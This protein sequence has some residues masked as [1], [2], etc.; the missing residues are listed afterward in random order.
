MIYERMVIVMMYVNIFELDKDN[1]FRFPVES[2]KLIETGKARRLLN[3]PYF[4]QNIRPND[5]VTLVSFQDGDTIVL[6]GNVVIN[7]EVEDEDVEDEDVEDVE[8]E[9]YQ[10]GLSE[11]WVGII[12]AK[13]F[14]RELFKCNFEVG[15][16]GALN[17]EGKH[18]E[19][20][21]FL[22]VEYICVEHPEQRVKC[23]IMFYNGKYENSA[24][25]GV[26]IMST[27]S[28][29]VCMHEKYGIKELRSIFLEE[30][31]NE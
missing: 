20:I 25:F 21:D 26:E 16:I 4:G 17:E 8:D 10:V 6:V 14:V 24:V 29:I 15:D 5:S 1:V 11:K 28:D 22:H 27:P 2:I 12:R 18:S 9:D 31:H 30:V 13:N 7:Y 23:C 19:F 3:L